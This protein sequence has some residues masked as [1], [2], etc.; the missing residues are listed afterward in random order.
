MRSLPSR[1]TIAGPLRVVLVDDGSA[2]GTGAIARRIGDPRSTVLTGTPGRQAGAASSGRKTQGIAESAREGLVLLTDADILHD[3]RHVATL[4]AQAE[5]G[6]FDLCLENGRAVMREP[7]RTRARAGLR[8]LLPTALPFAWVNDPLRAT[9]G[10]GRWYI[11]VRRRALERI[12]GIETIRSALHRRRGAGRDREE[13][14]RSRSGGPRA[15]AIR[16]AVSGGGRHLAHGG[17]HG[18]CAAPLFAGVAR[19]DDARHGADVLSRRSPRCSVT[20]RRAGLGSP[21][22]RGWR[23]RTLP[24]LRHFQRSL[25][26]APRCLASPC[27]TWRRR[28]AR[29]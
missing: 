7:R 10:G 24:T 18:L 9:G 12:G 17:A 1:R 2:D 3:P 5:R 22:G 11:L 6:G 4:A 14:R 20:A 16:A 27:S 19:R 29:R 26:W 8:V 23:S 21:L 25:L 13:G 28:S 15:G